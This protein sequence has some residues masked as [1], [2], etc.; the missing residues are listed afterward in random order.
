[1]SA[2]VLIGDTAGGAITGSHPPAY[3]GVS[4]ALQG[5]SVTAHAP[6]PTVPAH[7]AATMTAT[8]PITW[9]GVP[10]VQSGDPAT[11]GHASASS[12]ATSWT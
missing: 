10:V 9:N 4:V 8:C 3:N 1:M 2:I 12:V 7:C 11:C 5:D 6:C